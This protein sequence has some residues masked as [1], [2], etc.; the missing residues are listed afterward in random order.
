[1]AHDIVIRGGTVVDGTGDPARVVD[2]AIDGER[3]TAIGEISV[4]GHREIDATGHLV[5]PG[6]VDIHT[7][8]DA[9]IGWDPLVTSSCWHGVTSIVMGNCGMTF[10]P[11]KPADR[12][13]LARAMES[14][15]DIPA[16]AILDGLPWDWETY[17]EYLASLGR[18]PKGVNLGGMVGHSALRYWAMGDA[19]LDPTAVPTDAELAEMCELLAHGMAAGALGFST[20]RTLRHTA[21]D[22]RNVP[23]TFAEPRE[24]TALGDV[25]AAIGCGV[26]ELAPR[27]DGDGPSEPRARSEM[28]WMRELS[29]RT[30]R[31][32]T[33]NLTHT[34]ANPDHH[35]LIGELVADANAA[36]ANIRPQTTT[37][38]IGVLFALG[39]ATPFDRHESW[40]ALHDLDPADRVTALRAR[41]SQLLADAAEGPTAEQLAGFH[42]TGHDSPH[43]NFDCSPD[44]EIAAIAAGAG[45]TVGEAYLDALDRSDGTAVVYWPVLNQSMEAIGEM[46]SNDTIILGLADGG[47][48]VSQ[49]LDA[50]QPTW[51]LS[52]WVRDR[53]HVSIERGIQRLS[54]DGAQL[55]GLHDRGT[56]TAGSYADVN[57]IDLDRLALGL[58]HIVND[59]PHGAAR[60]VQ[61][62]DGYRAT[63]VNGVVSLEDGVH[64]GR[65]SGSLLLSGA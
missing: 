41:R 46:I 49:I 14:V 65:P 62:A 7:H 58:P 20:S 22:G 50:S 27:F 34:W 59:L 6:F 25:L 37:R 1:M 21:P 42:L 48:H 35:R 55:F 31:P 40:R 43:A 30:G 2:V 32:I 24:L 38:G 39:G 45:V 26:I 61:R 47:A 19:S 28:A 4:P 8:Y 13:T 23:G 18:T 63:I 54:Q 5:T 10:A 9:Q 64:V 3:I 51:F 53:R 44:T 60:F 16:A 15:E 36:G 52:H 33:F 11:C 17:D 57:V 12:E 29:I 56:L